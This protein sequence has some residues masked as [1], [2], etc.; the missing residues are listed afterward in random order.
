M[1]TSLQEALAENMRLRN[2]HS[3]LK[4][5][6]E[7]SVAETQKLRAEWTTLRNNKK[8][9]EEFQALRS[10]RFKRLLGDGKCLSI[11]FLL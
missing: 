6:L 1:K 2:D 4:K 10:G 7:E 11:C 9:L 5:E 8:S 3:E